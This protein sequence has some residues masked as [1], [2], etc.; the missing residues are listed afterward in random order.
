[1]TLLLRWKASTRGHILELGWHCEV[2]VQYLHT[3]EGEEITLSTID[4][5]LQGSWTKHT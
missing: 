4:R 2:A 5:I 3:W 1:M